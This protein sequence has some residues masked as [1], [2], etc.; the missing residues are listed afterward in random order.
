LRPRIPA[1]WPGY[2]LTYRWGQSR[3][4]IQVSRPGDHPDGREILLDGKPLDGDAIELVD[5]GGHHEVLVCLDEE[6]PG[7]AK[8]SDGGSG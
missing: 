3:Y 5:D 6:A 2:Q 7:T 4:H 1:A 8:I